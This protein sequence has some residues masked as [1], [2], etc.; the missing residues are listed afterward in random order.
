MG[1]DFDGIGRAF[2]FIFASLIVLVVVALAA[3]FLSWPVVLSYSPYAVVF[4][5]GLLIGLKVSA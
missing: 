5:A 4:S 1:Y 3:S 2:A